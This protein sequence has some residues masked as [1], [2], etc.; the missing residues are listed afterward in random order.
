MCVG[1][2]RIA[3]FGK[4]ASIILIEYNG[5]DTS[6]YVWIIFA[7][8]HWSMISKILFIQFVRSY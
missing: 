4:C 8:H 6:D 7:D 5:I 1:S 2:S 3:I